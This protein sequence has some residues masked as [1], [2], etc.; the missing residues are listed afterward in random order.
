MLHKKLYLNADLSIKDAATELQTNRTYLS[1]AVNT[2]LQQSFTSYINELRVK[3]GIKFMQSDDAKMYTMDAIASQIGFKSRSVFS[4]VF[5]K[6]TG[7]SPSFFMKNVHDNDKKQN[8]TDN[9]DSEPSQNVFE[10]V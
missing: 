1:K 6:Q 8:D 2:V 10:Q 5:K 9:Q 7:V 3:A 4:E